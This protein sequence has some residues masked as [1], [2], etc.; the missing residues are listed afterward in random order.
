MRIV[1]FA[2]EVARECFSYITPTRDNTASPCVVSC[3]VR[4]H[5]R[6]INIDFMIIMQ[7]APLKYSL[8]LVFVGTLVSL[9]ALSWALFG[10]RFGCKLVL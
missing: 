8:S 9:W 1:S 4:F 6:P 5:L 7:L 10:N 3:N 2:G